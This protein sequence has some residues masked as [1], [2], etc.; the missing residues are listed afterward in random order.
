MLQKTL[1]TTLLTIT[2]IFPLFASANHGLEAMGS[3]LE[4]LLFIALAIPLIIVGIA[5]IFAKKK[6]KAF[7]ITSLVGCGILVLVLF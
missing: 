1:K 5:A 3:A 6:A 7:L 4:A 2:A